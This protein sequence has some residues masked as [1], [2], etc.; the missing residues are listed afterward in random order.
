MHTLAN[1]L[2]QTGALVTTLRCG[3]AP[4]A[5]E[6]L[7]PSLV[8]LSPGPGNPRDFALS[9]TIDLALER[10]LPIFGV[11][12]GLQGIV[13]HYGGELGVLPYPQHGKPAL[14]TIQ[15]PRGPLLESLPASFQV[16]RYHSLHSKLDKQ[17]KV[18][19]TTAAT[20]DGCVMAIQHTT[21]PIAAVQFHPESI[22]TPHSLGLTM[23]ANAVTKLKWTD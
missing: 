5:L 11:C 22:L 14:V 17:P 10:K 9:T 18:L 19:R 4:S 1:Y 8:V 16:G 2:R 6:Q 7:Q 12:L 13:E 23:L 15:E 20:S 3:F 21:L